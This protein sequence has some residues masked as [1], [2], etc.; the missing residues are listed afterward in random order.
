MPKVQRITGLDIGTSKVCVLVAE[1][2][3]AGDLA[4]IGV[5]EAASEGL[6]KG[7]V[8]N[9]EK[10]VR[11]IGAAVA[12]AERMSGVK[13]SSVVVGVAGSHISAQNSRGLVAVTRPDRDI[14]AD[15]VHRVVDAARAVSV[16]SD[17]E[18][19]HVIPRSFVVD[20]QDGVR[21]AVGMT[22]SRLEVETHIVTGSTTA[23]QNVIKC[24]HAAGLSVDDIVLQ[25]LA[26]SE[27][28][29]TDNESELGAVVIDIGAGTTDVVVYTE[30]AVVHS[31]ALPV[32]GNHVTS[33]IAVVLRTSLADAEA[34]K[35]NYGHALPSA[36]DVDELVEVR[37]SGG[38]QVQTVPRTYLAEII[39]PRA[40]EIFELVRQ[41]IRRSGYDNLLPAG[42]VVTGGG[43]KLMGT[44]EVSQ[45]VLDMP[46]R[47]G[48]PG[49]IGGLSDR[50]SGPAY[51]TAVGL[52]RWGRGDGGAANS[53]FGAPPALA[54]AYQRT[55]K[56]LRD[57]F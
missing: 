30:G 2:D 16:P 35:L 1:I 10:T 14:T 39:G 27:A 23:V 52:V 17:R 40:R 26:S 32:G 41:E 19:I 43:S 46:V 6:R 7:V 24:V 20:G 38:D 18:V 11:S 8:V 57:F 55:V 15:D 33:D 56:W 29:L 50:V 31:A 51:S 44:I 28:V 42:A 3:D 49:G 5:G 4:V 54:G 36:I 12:N 13:L 25:G 21:E 47:I 45:A 9:I 53:H 22:G 37:Q 48:L 34:L